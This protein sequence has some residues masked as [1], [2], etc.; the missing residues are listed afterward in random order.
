MEI[1]DDKGFVFLDDR[2]CPY[3]CCMW[4]DQP[5]LFYWHPEKHWVSLRPVTQGE[6]WQMPRNLSQEEQDVYNDLHDEYNNQF[7][8]TL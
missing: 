8:T 4:G 1:L 2:G 3:R 7:E 6:I 5:W